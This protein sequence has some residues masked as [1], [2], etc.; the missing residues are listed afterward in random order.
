M[1]A[2]LV[3][4]AGIGGLR[5]DTGKALIPDHILNEPD[6]LSEDESD[7]ARRHHAR[8]DGAVLPGPPV[9]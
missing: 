7:I 3:Y 1:D 9:R 8:C 2:D 4:Q 6:R 5:H